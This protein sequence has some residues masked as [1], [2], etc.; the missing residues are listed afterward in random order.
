MIRRKLIYC[1]CAL[2]IAQQQIGIQVPGLFKICKT[3]DAMVNIDSKIPRSHV[4]YTLLNL[5]LVILWILGF[6]YILLLLLCATC[7]VDVSRHD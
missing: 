4:L 6:K 1:I 2:L 7:D 3:V 5:Y